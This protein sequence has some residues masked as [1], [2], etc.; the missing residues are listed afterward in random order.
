[1]VKNKNKCETHTSICCVYVF[2]LQ[3]YTENSK[4]YWFMNFLSDFF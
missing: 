4:E 3:Q 1:M 2:L